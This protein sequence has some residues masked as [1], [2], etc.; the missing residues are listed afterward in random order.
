MPH[1]FPK[2]KLTNGLFGPTTKNHFYKPVGYHNKSAK[3]KKDKG[4]WIL[5][6]GEQYE[7]FRLSDEG[8]WKCIPNQGLFSILENGNV[9]FG[10]NEERLAYFPNPQNKNDEWHGYPVH[11]SEFEISDDLIE[12]LV[13]E[14]VID[15]R[16]SIK[17]LKGQ[18]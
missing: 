9:I 18:L 13:E 8:E 16:I 6:Q 4:K 12:K 1:K 17:I 2:Y 15:I 5:K 11:S 3:T 14:D 10:E 7:V